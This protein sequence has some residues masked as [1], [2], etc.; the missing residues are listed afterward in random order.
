MTASSPVVLVT[1]AS[2]AIGAATAWAFGGG[3]SATTL[4]AI[5]ARSQ[6]AGEP[7]PEHHHQVAPA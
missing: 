5:T 3:A 4:T 2:P 1:G 6:V 7:A